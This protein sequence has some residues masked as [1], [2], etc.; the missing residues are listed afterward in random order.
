MHPV[1]VFKENTY[2]FVTIAKLQSWLTNQ[3][4]CGFNHVQDSEN[5]T[6]VVTE[7]ARHEVAIVERNDSVSFC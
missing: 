6:T 2:F 1:K 5:Q 7:M 4:C 3:I